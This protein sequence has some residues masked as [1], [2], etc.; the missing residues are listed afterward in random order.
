MITITKNVVKY[1]ILP[2][3]LFFALFS[4]DLQTRPQPGAEKF[5]G[6]ELPS[7]AKVAAEQLLQSVSI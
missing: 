7:E 6:K 3:F 1:S 5:P 2:L 4:S